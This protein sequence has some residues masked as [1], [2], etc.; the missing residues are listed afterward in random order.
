MA[1]K[2][3]KTDRVMRGALETQ[4]ASMIFVEFK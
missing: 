4:H 1:W 3:R 2:V